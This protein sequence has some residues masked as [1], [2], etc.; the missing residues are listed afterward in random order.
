ML[1]NCFYCNTDFSLQCQKFGFY[2]PRSLNHVFFPF[3]SMF[4]DLIEVT[5]KTWT[6]ALDEFF[7]QNF[8]NELCSR[9]DTEILIINY[10]FK[11]QD[12]E[13]IKFKTGESFHQFFNRL[14][15][16][17][18]ARVLLQIK[19]DSRLKDENLS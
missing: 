7:K 10:E 5:Q 12:V 14:E 11:N 1:S 3:I 19:E 9:I 18:T 6:V 13:N 15:E 17:Y 16:K 2:I 8:C 4:E